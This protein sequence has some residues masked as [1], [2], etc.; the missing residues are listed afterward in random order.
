MP[1]CNRM[2]IAFVYDA[3]YPY[4][5][6]GVER[7]VWELAVR[8]SRNGHEVHVFGMKYWDGDD[9]LIRDGVLLHGVCPAQSL[10][11]GGRRTI[12]EAVWFAAR[13]L[14]HLARYHFDIIDCQQ[15]PYLSCF[16]AK[17]A[18]L[19]K[20]I[21]LVITWHEF[22]GDYWYD[23][24]GI[25]GFFGKAIERVAS[26]LSLNRIAVSETT[27]AALAKAG[28]T[29]TV[30]TI[31]NGIDSRHI[32]LIPTAGE[33]TDIIFVG[34]LIRDKHADLLI[35]AFAGIAAEDPV[36]ILR[37]IGEGPEREHLTG[38]VHDLGLTDRV[39]LHDF[40]KN[41]EDLI[42]RM[43]SARIFVLPSTREGF[44][45]AALEALACGLP[46]VTVDH[47]KNAI[48]NLVTEKTGFLCALSVEDL[49][50]AMKNAL[51]RHEAMREDC[52]AASRMFEWDRITLLCEEYYRSV[53]T[54][55]SDVPGQTD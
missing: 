54:G 43:K 44:G 29:T 31:P 41:Y 51:L 16:T 21:P 2:K 26:R 32:T 11:A 30:V 52:I 38:I 24:L 55:T 14:P 3:V 25:P 47:P 48:R 46:V 7:R 39:F 36:L 1:E 53:I 37:I 50:M 17:I 20:G 33:R 34:R 10:Y 9:I 23:Y 49:S 40:E 22:W 19:L 45:M 35:R 15:F 8:L 18:A 28:S 6:G 27:S 42:A 4:V 5:K 12:F 13:L